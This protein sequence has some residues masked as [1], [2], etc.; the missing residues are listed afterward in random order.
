MDKNESAP[1]TV[2]VVAALFILTGLSSA[3][4]VLIRL[5]Q[6]S[7]FLNFGVLG[8]FIGIGLLRRSRGWR[9]CALVFLWI[10]MIGL[11]L[12]AV[13]LLATDQPLHY[14]LFSREMGEAPK[15]AGVA[16]AAVAFALTLWQYWV[17]TRPH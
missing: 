15:S 9:T 2:K 3:L 4:D 16:V 13:L 6:G 8:L 11:P 7:L 1:V 12:A 14:T 5:T 10:A 17:L